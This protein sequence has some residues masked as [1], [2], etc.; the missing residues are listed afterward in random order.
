MEIDSA[1]EFVLTKRG[2]STHTQRG[3]PL[4]ENK[5]KGAIPWL[6]K[7]LKIDPNI[8]AVPQV[9]KLAKG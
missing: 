4:P 3:Q 5:K 2:C 8:A 9:L 1:I 7:A 6:E